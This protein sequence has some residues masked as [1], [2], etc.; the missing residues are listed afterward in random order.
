MVKP[1][2]EKD[3]ARL[4][5]KERFRVKLAFLDTQNNPFAGK[6]LKGKYQGS[7]SVKVWPY[8]ILYEINQNILTI[9]VL[10]IKHRGGG[11]YA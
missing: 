1:R 7:Y 11:A 5:E 8:R 10:K 2:A 6:K 3:L 9:F 4:P